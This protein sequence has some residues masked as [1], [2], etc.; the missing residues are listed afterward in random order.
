MFVLLFATDRGNVL[1]AEIYNFGRI[2]KL[3]RSSDKN[4]FILL[5]MSLRKMS[6]HELAYDTEKKP[7]ASI[8]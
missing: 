6:L 8:V 1:L 5:S 4:N 7:N 2:Q 3:M